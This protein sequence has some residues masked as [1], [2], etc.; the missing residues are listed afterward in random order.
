M[1]YEWDIDPQKAPATSGA[2]SYTAGDPPFAELHLWPYRSLPRRGFA[3]I[4]GMAFLLFLIPL[5]AFIGTSSLW[6]LLPFAMGALWLLWFFIEK[7]YRDAEILEELRIWSDH[8]HLSHRGP[9][10]QHF[11]WDANP[12][13]VSAHLRKSGGPVSNYLTLKGNG[14]EVELGAFL[15]ED[16][17]PVL[18]RKLDLALAQARQADINSGRD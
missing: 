2:F 15:S 14:R 4:I 17:R 1:P 13:W 16:E 11:E 3:G 18:H 9:K 6:G 10:G 12:Y 8:V 7:S 5:F